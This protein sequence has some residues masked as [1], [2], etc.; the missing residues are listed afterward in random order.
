MLHNYNKNLKY[1]FYQN[2]SF[3]FY[4]IKRRKLNTF[5]TIFYENILLFY[6]EFTF[7]LR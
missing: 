2:L 7:L 1:F 3:Y 5:G 6:V 4:Q